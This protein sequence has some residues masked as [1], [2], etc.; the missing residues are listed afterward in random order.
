[1][2]SLAWILESTILY[3][4]YTRIADVRI[5]FAASLVFL[6]GI[7][8]QFVLVGSLIQSDYISLLILIIAMLAV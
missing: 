6:I 8:R 4:V 7:I 2:M 3:L 1:M 5:F